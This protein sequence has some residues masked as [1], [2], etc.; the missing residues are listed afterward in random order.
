MNKLIASY[1]LPRLK[2]KN[3]EILKRP[4]TKIKIKVVIPTPKN[5]LKNIHW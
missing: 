2:H 5:R 1:N 4:R 3:I